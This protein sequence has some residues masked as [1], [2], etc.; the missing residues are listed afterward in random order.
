MIPTPGNSLIV[1]N[2]VACFVASTYHFDSVHVQPIEVIRQPGRMTVLAGD[3]RAD[4]T[5]GQR[6]LLGL[7]LRAV[8]RPVAT[9]PAWAALVDPLAR[10]IL[11][12]VRTRV[13]PAPVA[14][15]GTELGTSIRWCL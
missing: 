3:L 2:E 7:L 6:S 12:G 9:S 13:S 15:S 10:I 14:E 4:L 1:H 11:P 8:P 5:V